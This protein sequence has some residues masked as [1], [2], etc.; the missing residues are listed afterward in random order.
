MELPIRHDGL[1]PDSLY[2]APRK[3]ALRYYRSEPEKPFLFPLINENHFCA[4]SNCG[5]VI[6]RNEGHN[7][8]HFEPDAA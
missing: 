5:Y 7:S 3:L 8:D 2:R 1:L 6:A 4:V